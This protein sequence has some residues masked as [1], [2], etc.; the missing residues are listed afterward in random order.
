MSFVIGHPFLLSGSR[1]E[2]VLTHSTPASLSVA[3]GE[4]LTISCRASEDIS[5][6]L[7][8]YQQPPGKPPKSLIYDADLLESGVPAR[9]RGRGS[10]TDFNPTIHS[11]EAEDGAH[12]FCQQGYDSPT[13]ALSPVK[14][15]L[16]IKHPL[17]H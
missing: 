5:D 12:Y 11:V 10:G 15:E 13:P 17:L 14:L 8:W 16:G 9:F 3:L 6:Y 1:E 7:T 4:T 2:I